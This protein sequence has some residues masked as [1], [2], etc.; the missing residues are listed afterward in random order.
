M[1][2]II[3]FFF[4]FVFV[5]CNS[6]QEDDPKNDSY[7]F[8]P[9][10]VSAP[11]TP[12]AKK[13]SVIVM[14]DNNDDPDNKKGYAL[15]ETET[16]GELKYGQSEKKVISVLGEPDEKLKAEFWDGD[17]SYHRTW[18]YKTSDVELDFS[19]NDSL[20]MNLNSI[21]INENCSF[22]TSRNIGIGA[23]YAEVYAAYKNEATGNNED[24]TFLIAG[25]IYGGVIFTFQDKKLI[26]VFVGSSAE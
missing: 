20:N 12:V 2:K 5:S 1:K 8:T 11:A 21:R 18:K 9:D 15:M 4:L 17:G 13:D 19:G 25:S 23:S 16:I 3:P 26:S 14:P 22:K 10:P 6:P 7:A 24:A